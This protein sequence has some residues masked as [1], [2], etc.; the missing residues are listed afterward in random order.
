MVIGV[1]IM[2][3]IICLLCCMFCVG[4]AYPAAMCVKDNTTAVFFPET[5]R[6]VA[7][8]AQGSNI[9]NKTWYMTY[10]WGTISGIAGC[11]DGPETAEL[12]VAT[13]ESQAAVTTQTTGSKAYAKILSPFETDWI[14]LG[15][16][17]NAGT[18]AN[19]VASTG[20]YA[21]TAP[22]A[23]RYQT[24]FILMVQNAW[25]KITAQMQ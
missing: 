24:L 1:G 13:A 17:G 10:S 18:C 6:N 23:L 8:K 16:H 15:N 19:R 9:A 5:V 4:A 20:G 3:K 21:S 2:K 14:Y 22:Y 7:P 12:S 25:G 11:Y